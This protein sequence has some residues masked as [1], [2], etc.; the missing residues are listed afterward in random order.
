MATS[1]SIVWPGEETETPTEPLDSFRQWSIVQF[2]PRVG[3][4]SAIFFVCTVPSESIDC[5]ATI[6]VAAISA[7][8]PAIVA[9]L[10]TPAVLL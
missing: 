5:Y 2:V 6:Q 3:L 8:V 1:S 10:F 4:V 9:V 7:S